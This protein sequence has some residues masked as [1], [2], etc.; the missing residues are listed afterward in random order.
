MS[1]P[2]PVERIEGLRALDRVADRIRPAASRVVGDRGRRD[3]LTGRWLGH[4]AHPAAVLVPTACWL[5]A[6][7]LDVTGGRR[8]RPAA[9]RLSGLGLL[10]AVPASASG[11][12]DWIDTSGAER[13]V[14]MVHAVGNLA[15]GS[16]YALSWS[17]RRDGRPA[18][19]T[20]ASLLGATVLGL[21]GY[22][23]GHLA[24]RRGVGVNTTAFGAGP[25]EWTALPDP[26]AE[27]GGSSV[28]EGTV[29]ATSIDGTA[30]AIVGR[31]DRSPAVLEARCTH[32]GGPLHEGDTDDGC[33][34][35]PWH[36]SRFD[37]A[38]GAVRTGPASVP[39]PVYDT[40]VVDGTLEIRRDEPGGL[41]ANPVGAVDLP[42]DDQH[43][44]GR[45]GSIGTPRPRHTTTTGTRNRP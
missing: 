30:L 38:T 34:R 35:C 33:I 18:S 9:Q 24:Y 5:G 15:A 2:T 4:P 45:H 7:F 31:A 40:R 28:P 20:V 25:T 12:A 8:S 27:P 26:T 13:R 1:R 14:G 44:P 39:Q 6:T 21:T 3:L 23:G 42:D 11:V 37:I 32:R 10:A 41:R 43:R 19:A 17:R 36:G 22:L 29:R 16:L